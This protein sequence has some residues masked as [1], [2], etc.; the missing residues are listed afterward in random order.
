MQ[1]KPVS[2]LGVGELCAFFDQLVEFSLQ[3]RH[4][5]RQRFKLA[6]EVLVDL[7]DSFVLVE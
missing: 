7:G 1:I 4:Q 2:V 5:I 6:Q 3:M